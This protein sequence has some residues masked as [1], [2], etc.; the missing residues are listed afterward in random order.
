MPVFEYK[1]LTQNGRQTKGLIDADSIRSARLKLKQQGIYP[2]SL[3]ETRQREKIRGTT[4]IFEFRRG[5]VSATQLG[6]ATR[7]LS[8]LVGAGM[9]L[10]EALRALADQV[11]DEY[12]KRVIG[13]VSD[14]VNE[15][16]TMAD[17]LKSYP[18]IFPRL[19]VNMVASGEASGSASFEIVLERLA[20]L[21]ES[22]AALRRK[23]MAALT[24]PILMLFL[25]LGVVIL[26]LAFVVPQITA[27]FKEQK[28]TLPVPTRIVIALSNFAQDYWW[29]IIAA[30]I[31]VALGLKKYAATAA[32]RKRLDA[33]K[34]RLPIFGAIHLKVATS[35]F[36]RNLGTL[37][38]SGVEILTA[39]S[40]V[41]NIIGNVLLENAIE[42]AS[43]GVREGKSLA[44]ELARANLFPRMLIHMISIGEKTGKL[45]SMLGRAANAYDSE[46][47]AVVTGLT[48]LLEPIL[49]FFLAGIVGVILASVMLPMLEMSSLSG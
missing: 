37:L 49:I 32:G 20:D 2:T 5:K 15:G 1:A 40:I 30:I 42:S 39:L 35:R 41:K 12:I 4:T 19:F 9:P 26:L 23:I 17:A 13:E 21:L 31:F 45:E 47:N 36:A 27:I 33:L 28:A 14:R 8:T 7:Q 18:R 29:A 22:Q 43:E 10:V 16:T 48:A 46:V 6:L 11:D 25:C 3:L 44:A 24:Y 38:G 34:L